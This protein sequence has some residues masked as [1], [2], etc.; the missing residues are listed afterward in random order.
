[1]MDP[2]RDEAKAT[3]ATCLA[4]GIRTIMITGDQPATAAEIA[5]SSGSTTTRGEALASDAR[6]RPDGLDDAGWDGS[7]GRPRCSRASRRSTS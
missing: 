2:L 1:M 7:S 4:A 3:I 6:P 5:A